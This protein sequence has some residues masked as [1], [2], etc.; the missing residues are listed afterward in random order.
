MPHPQ[1]S[2]DDAEDSNCSDGES[3]PGVE[4]EIGETGSG[5]SGEEEAEMD[6]EQGEEESTDI[7]PSQVHGMVDDCVQKA[8]RGCP[9]IFLQQGVHLR[10]VSSKYIV[11]DRLEELSILP[12]EAAESVVLT[13]C[14]IATI[15]D[16]FC[17]AADGEAPFPVAV[18][19]NLSPEEK[20]A[21]LMVVA[22]GKHGRITSFC[23][24]LD[25][26]EDRE[27]FMEA[28]RLL[29][30]ASR[31]SAA[32][33]HREHG[34]NVAEPHM[35][36]AMCAIDALPSQKVSVD[37]FMR[38]VGIKAMI[39]GATQCK[40][41]V[42]LL[43]LMQQEVVSYISAYGYT[44]KDTD[45]WQVS[46]CS[47]TRP[48]VLRPKFQVNVRQHIEAAKHTWYIVESSLLLDGPPHRLDWLAPRRLVHIRQYLYD[49]VKEAF[50]VEYKRHL[51]KTGFARRMGL[52]GTTERLRKWLSD[53]A[54]T[55]NSRR[56][57][58][59]IV[60][61]TLH[62]LEAPCLSDDIH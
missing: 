12:G 6:D 2:G 43:P 18:I 47:Q 7:Q 42:P 44:P 38:C 55:I 41:G 52:P 61:L 33:D 54:A 37:F 36:Q 50:G 29:C 26:P 49:P 60:A 13:Q 23:M 5:S 15:Q 11:D 48:K 17:V 27:T 3:E 62:F 10:R 45:V 30:V 24:L 31:F 32:V 59:L 51:G 25:S 46:S 16:I 4:D 56:A 28:M 57:P 9:C 53:L 19:G 8:R 35:P 1:F 39:P 21:L 14:L 34:V 40:D 20:E 22:Q 58:P